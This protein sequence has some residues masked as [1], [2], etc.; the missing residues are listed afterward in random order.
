[1][2]SQNPIGNDPKSL[3]P[4]NDAAKAEKPS[5]VKRELTDEEIAAVAGGAIRKPG[6]GPQ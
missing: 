4:A 5:E 2:T 3:T 6:P 1:M